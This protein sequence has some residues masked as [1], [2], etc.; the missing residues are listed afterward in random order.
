MLTPSDR[1]RRRGPDDKPMVDPKASE[2]ARPLY[3]QS[4]LACH[5][6]DARGTPQGPNLVR[7]I[8]VL[9]DRYGSTLG[10]FLRAS[11][12]P[13]PVAG[14]GRRADAPGHS[15]ALTSQEV[16]LLSHFLRD[17]VNDTLRGAPMFKPGNVL[18]GDAEGRRRVLPGRGRLHAVPFADRRPG[19]HRPAARAG[20][21]PAALPVPA[22]G[23]AHGA[24]RQ[25]RDRHRD[26]RIGRDAD[27]RRWIGW[28]TSTCRSATRPGT[29]HSVR[30][31]PGT[32]VVK[33]DPFAA[34]VALLSRITDKNMHDVVAYLETPEMIRLGLRLLVARSVRLAG[35][36]RT[37]SR[38]TAGRP[39]T[40]TT[41]AG[42]SARSR[43]ST[44]TTSSTSASRGATGCRRPAPA[45]IKGTPL[46]V[47][48]IAYVTVPDHVWAIDA[49]T[50]REVWH[51][52]WKGKGGNHI[53]NR[54]VG[55]LGDCALFRD[56]GLPPRLAR[57]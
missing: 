27:G 35:R 21:P 34:H 29:Y 55:I 13:V 28:T 18:T 56:A 26:D 41:R 40:A 11:H 36:R 7:S 43:R 45:P 48:G 23:A 37:R 42:A 2:A 51:F 25:G 16:L 3:A 24:G 47:N 5:G 19:R 39:T 14:P 20:H 57:A 32:R 1:P 10:P 15:K 54:G 44:P 33:T 52:E 53:G 30:R 9:H 22:H 49:R 12:P 17:R 8:V 4:C 38:P 31:T 46:V 50:G 6:A